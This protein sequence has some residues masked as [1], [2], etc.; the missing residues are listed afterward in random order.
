MTPWR[1][2]FLAAAAG[3]CLPMQAFGAESNLVFVL[4]GSGSMWGRVGGSI[5]IVEAK[6]VMGDLLADVPSGVDIS[7]VAYG[8]RRKGDCTDIETLAAF[9]TPSTTIA[10]QVKGLTP[11]GK[12]PI[13][14]SL[15]KGA[16]QLAG[17][18][19]PSS[20]VLVSDG[21]ETCKGDPCALAETLRAGGI[22]LVISTLR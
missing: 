17:R 22:E 1:G 11:L 2:V 3:C 12:T 7:L 8:H 18:D 4:D 5:K 21:I 10:E 19:G 15:Q 13:T 9:G 14:D 16:D 6:Q 20:L